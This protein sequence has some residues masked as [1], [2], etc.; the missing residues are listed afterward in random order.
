MIYFCGSGSRTAWRISGR[1]GSSRLSVSL[2]HATPSGGRLSR[3]SA[4]Q[5]WATE[6]PIRALLSTVRRLHAHDLKSH[7]IERLSAAL[8]RR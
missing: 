4:P 6:C 8:P 5:G 3:V 2:V 1:V 7:G